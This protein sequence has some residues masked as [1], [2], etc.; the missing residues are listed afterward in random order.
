ME[1][2]VTSNACQKIQGVRSN[3]VQ[4]IQDGSIFFN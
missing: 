4:I 3:V 1:N 2:N